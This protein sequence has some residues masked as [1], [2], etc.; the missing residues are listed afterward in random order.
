MRDGSVGE[1]PPPQVRE[2]WSLHPR[3]RCA[4]HEPAGGGVGDAGARELALTSL[5]LSLRLT[6]NMRRLSEY[7]VRL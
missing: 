3:S 1:T 7:L 4:P 2:Q 6:E 5:S